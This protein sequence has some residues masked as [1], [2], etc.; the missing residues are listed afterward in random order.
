MKTLADFPTRHNSLNILRVLLALLVIVSHVWPLGG[1]GEDPGVGGVTL[2]SVAVAGFFALSGWLI[3]ASRLTSTLPSYLW[4]RAVRIYPGYLAAVVAVAFVFAPLGAA[5]S[6]GTYSPAAG[7]EYVRANLGLV[8]LQWSVGASLP[9]DRWPAW[10]GSLWTLW[11]EV[12]CYLLIGLVVSVVDRRRL[13]AVLVTALLVTTAA[14]FLPGGAGSWVPVLL[15]DWAGLVPYFLAG[16][17]LH[18]VRDRIRLRPAGVLVAAALVWWVLV[19]GAPFTL[20]AV[21]LA[22]VLLWVAAVAPFQGFGT[23]HDLSYGLY[24]Y[25]FPVQQLLAVFGAANAGPGWFLVASVAG[26]VPVAA[27]SWLW[28]ERPAQRWRGLLDPVRPTARPWR[29]GA[30]RPVPTPARPT[31][32]FRAPGR[33]AL[34][35]TPQ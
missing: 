1:F 25:A 19:M 33:S 14:Q 26:T 6:S 29:A 2:G 35:W 5:A 21:P 10:N 28:V 24:I 16:A 22:Y 20:A 34:S 31:D 7:W 11:S 13:P 23:R 3:T 12:V 17:V 27:A 9:A 18:V 4:R 15:R 30:H 32:D 8:Q